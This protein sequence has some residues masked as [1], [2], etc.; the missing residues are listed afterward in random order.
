MFHGGIETVLI[1][2][3]FKLMHSRFIHAILS[4]CW[5]WNL[6]LS[7]SFTRCCNLYI[8]KDNMAREA[9]ALTLSPV[10]SIQDEQM[11]SPSKMNSVI[12]LI[13]SYIAIPGGDGIR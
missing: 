7:L 3:K 5:N 11:V 12:M 13:P 8:C 10:R 6:S 2:T 1:L 4:S 9:H